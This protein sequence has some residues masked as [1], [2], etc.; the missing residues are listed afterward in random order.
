M[1]FKGL[2]ILNENYSNEFIQQWKMIMDIQSNSCVSGQ[3]KYG[4][5]TMTNRYVENVNL[6]LPVKK[7]RLITS[8]NYKRSINHNTKICFRTPIIHPSQFYDCD[9]NGRRNDSFKIGQ[10]TF[11]TPCA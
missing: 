11:E 10:T 6:N 1:S 9:R 4:S 5:N 8:V 7:V 3:L 2:T